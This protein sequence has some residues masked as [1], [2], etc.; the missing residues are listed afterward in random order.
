[1]FTTRHELVQVKFTRPEGYRYNLSG[2]KM[3]RTFVVQKKRNTFYVNIVSPQ[4]LRFFEK[5]STNTYNT[6]MLQNM[7]VQQH[8][9]VFWTRPETVQVVV[10]NYIR[11]KNQKKDM[12]EY[13]LH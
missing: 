7:N 4:V 2:R 12:A 8:T 3:L 10:I 1:M 11:K 13:R 5:L 6:R 9:T